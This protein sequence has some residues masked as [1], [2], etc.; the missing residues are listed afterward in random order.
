MY[1]NENKLLS[2][3]TTPQPAPTAIP[4][5]MT[6]PTTARL[7][8]SGF[9]PPDLTAEQTHEDITPTAAMMSQESMQ[10]DNSRCLCCEHA[11]AACARV[12]YR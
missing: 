4:G 10:L 9:A 7:D 8:A 5:R 1:E 3:N 11:C 12:W 6:T 2:V